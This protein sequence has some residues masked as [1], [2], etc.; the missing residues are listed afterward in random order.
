MITL[1]KLRLEMKLVAYNP[2]FN[3]LSHPSFSKSENFLGKVSVDIYLYSADV[4]CFVPIH[5]TGKAKLD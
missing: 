3:F 5:L 1:M 2:A 4:Q